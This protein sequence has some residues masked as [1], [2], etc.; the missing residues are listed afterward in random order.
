MKFIFVDCKLNH[1]TTLLSIVVYFIHPF[2]T[3]SIELYSVILVLPGIH[4]WVDEI[5]LSKILNPIH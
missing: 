3:Y 2:Y 1:S 4:S 5:C